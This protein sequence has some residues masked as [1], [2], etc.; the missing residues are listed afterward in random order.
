[1]QNI[2][3]AFRQVIMKNTNISEG[4]EKTESYSKINEGRIFQTSSL[5][6]VQLR[7]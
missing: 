2:D 3:H 1:M 4:N 7:V 5:W 6:N